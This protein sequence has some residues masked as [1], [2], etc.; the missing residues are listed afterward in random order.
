MKLLLTGFEPFAGSPVNPSEMIMRALLQSGV[1]GW[2]VCSAILPVER[3]Q[4]SAAILS[5]LRMH[6]PDA[7]VSLGQATGRAAISIER[8]AVNLEDYTIPDNGGNLVSDEPVVPGGPAAYFATVP[9]RAM[10][11]AAHAAGIPAEL[12]LSAGAYLCN[13]VLYVLLHHIT[14]ERLP[15]RAGFIHVPM[16]PQQVIGRA[17][18]TPSMSLETMTAGVRAALS[19]L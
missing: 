2:D 1:D 3:L 13:Q 15:M 8:I 4:A 9:V 6:G 12:S 11:Q 18:P 17:W 7:V 5:A 19:A 10:M 14:S 16:L